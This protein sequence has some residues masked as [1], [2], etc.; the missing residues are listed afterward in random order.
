MGPR[1]S[2]STDGAGGDGE[3]V[4]D[5]GIGCREQAGVRAKSKEGNTLKGS[6][7]TLIIFYCTLI[8][9]VQIA[10]NVQK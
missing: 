6:I 5:K 7:L 3:D 1:V 2:T 8:L 10:K 9:N 4:E